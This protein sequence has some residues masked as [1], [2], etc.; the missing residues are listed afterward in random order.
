MRGANNCVRLR[1]CCLRIG[2]CAGNTEVHDLD[3]ALG[4]QHDVAGLDIA[5]DQASR[6]RVFQRRENAGNNVDDLRNGEGTR[7]VREQVLQRTPINVFHDDVRNR[8]STPIGED[9]WFFTGVVNRN[10]VWVVK[11]SRGLG[12]T[13]ETRLEDGIHRQVGAKSL[14]CNDSRQTLVE[15]EVNFGHPAAPD[16][17]AHL[18][19]SP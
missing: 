7:I 3:F 13:T 18:V 15:S 10:D 2:D 17:R 1:H 4:S 19:A 12:L 8:H 14:N 16:E 6:M 11:R 5:V 9:G